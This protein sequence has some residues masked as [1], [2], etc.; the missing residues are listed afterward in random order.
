MLTTGKMPVLRRYY[1]LLTTLNFY[2][3]IKK[4]PNE[5]ITIAGRD[6][7]DAKVYIEKEVNRKLEILKTIEEQESEE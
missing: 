6:G 3:L 2:A 1:E 4:V 7:D 5:P